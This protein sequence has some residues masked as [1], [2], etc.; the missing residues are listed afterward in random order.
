MAEM[1]GRA[2]GVLQVCKL[3]D[4]SARSRTPQLCLQG[5]PFHAS[6]LPIDSISGPMTE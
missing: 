5:K 4:V 1:Q 3:G 2:V 6:N